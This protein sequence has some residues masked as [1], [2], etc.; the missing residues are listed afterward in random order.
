MKNKIKA[1]KINR[2]KDIIGVIGLGYVG[3]PLA[4]SFSKKIEV[5]AYDKKKLRTDNLRI[6]KDTNKEVSK[7]ELRNKQNILFT[8]DPKNLSKCNIFIITVPTPV[9]HKN[10]PNLDLLKEACKLVGKYIKKEAIVIIESTTYPGCTEEFCAP[11]IEKTSRLKFNK[12]FYCGYSPE[13][14]NPGDKKNKLEKIVKITSGSNT[15]TAIKVDRLYKKIIKAGTYKVSSIKVAEAAKIVENVQRFVNISLINELAIIFDKLNLSS[16]E[17]LNAAGTKWNFLKFKPGLIGGHC[18]AV[19]PYYLSYKAKKIKSKSEII[20][21]SLR[22]HEKLFKYIC[23]KLINNLKSNSI[24]SK[25]NVLILGLTFK[26]NCHDYRNSQ[27]VKLVQ[28]LKSKKFKVDAYDPF[29]N[30][31]DIKKDYNINML[32]KFPKKNYYDGIVLAVPHNFF[33][34]LG[35]KKIQG[36]GKKNFQ[37]ID[38]KSKLKKNKYIWQF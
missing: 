18:I 12:D 21:T 17:V 3:L 7:K 2:K 34:N 37:L 6:G 11:I 29:I 19:D 10:I 31:K 22:L 33:L 32:K 27:S 35:Q 16:E 15:K 36:F 38:I 30:P 8:N 5:V 28:Y 14:I 4:I 24:T 23:N 9:K 26:E 1:K 13:R 25:K 20:N